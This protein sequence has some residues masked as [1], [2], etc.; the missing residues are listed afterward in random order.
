MEFIQYG[1]ECILFFIIQNLV[2]S[3]VNRHEYTQTILQRRKSV[4][5]QPISERVPSNGIDF[6]TH[7]FL[8]VPCRE[9]RT[10]KVRRFL[11]S[12][13]QS[14]MTKSEVLFGKEESGSIQPTQRNRNFLYDL[15]GQAASIKRSSELKMLFMR[16]S[17][18]R[19]N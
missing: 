13:V 8:Q 9:I 17:Y 14:D 7:F 1:I 11:L 12:C 5:V 2:N 6:Y 10:P 18:S 15:G 3:R 19:E 16:M 4:S